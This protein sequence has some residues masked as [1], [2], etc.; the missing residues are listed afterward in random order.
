[1]SRFFSFLLEVFLFYFSF[2][3][4]FLVHGPKL[5][6]YDPAFNKGTSGPIRDR[7]I[8]R[9]PANPIFTQY[10]Y[11]IN[12]S[13][14]T[15]TDTAAEH[16]QQT[17]NPYK[18]QFHRIKSTKNDMNTMN[19]IFQARWNSHK[20]HNITTISCKPQFPETSISSFHQEQH[21]NSNIR[22]QIESTQINSQPQLMVHFRI[23]TEPIQALT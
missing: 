2:L 6:K 8:I 13:H 9:I 23:Q 12:C 10:K 19:E 5:F 22:F 21:T 15:Q 14:C 16:N 11:S 1:M 4:S 18:F 7:H 3:M 20:H 17:L